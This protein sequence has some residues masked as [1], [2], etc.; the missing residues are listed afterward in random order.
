MENSQNKKTP[1][2]EAKSF[3]NYLK[4]G[5][6]S[7]QN[8]N[9]RKAIEYYSLALELKPADNPTLVKLGHA[10]C[11]QDDKEQGMDCYLQALAIDEHDVWAEYW[12]RTTRYYEG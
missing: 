12:L 5:D 6:E 7:S 8:G 11:N 3:D 2:P 1:K 10:F 4:K 9:T